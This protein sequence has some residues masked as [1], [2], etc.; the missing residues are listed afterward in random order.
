MVM[1]SP[2]ATTADALS[3]TDAI[4]GLAVYRRLL[5]YARPHWRYLSIAMLAM[6][7]HATTETGFA[8]L[9]G[10]L[11]DG[12]FVNQD[13]TMIRWIPVAVIGI[14][15]VRAVAGFLSDYLMG[16]VAHTVVKSLRRD[17]FAHL[18]RLPV[19]YY[20]NHSSG[21]L[22]SM[23][24]Y[25]T[26]QVAQAT[27]NAVTILV[28]DTLTIIGLLLWMFYLDWRL[29]LGF[30]LIG[31]VITLLV[32]WVT[33]QFR[34]IS[35]RIQHSMGAI[36]QVAEEVL[37][38]QRVVKIFGGEAYEAR[39]FERVNE[40]TRRMN[41]KMSMVK[42]ANMPFLQFVVAIAV[43]AILYLATRPAV[44][45]TLTVGTFMS[46]VAAMLM[47]LDPIRHLTN[48][49][50][51]IQR[52]IAAGESVF[53][54]MATPAEQDTGT[55]PLQRAAGHIEYQDVHLTYDPSKGEVLR[56]IGF[57]VRPGERIALVG[58]S[59]GG[60]SSLV[61]LLPR[62]YEVSEGRILLDGRD[63]RDY[64]LADLRTQI[65]YVG[66]DVTLFNDSIR[67]NIAYGRLE[68]V[69]TA[70]IWEAAEAAHAREFIERLP[71]GLDTLVGDNGVLLSGGQRQR[72]AIA[73]ALLKDAPIL[74]LDEATSSL[75]MEAERHIQDA[76]EKLIANRTTLVIAH[77]LATVEDADRI[78]VLENGQIVEA[79]SHQELLARQGRYAGLY[80]SQFQPLGQPA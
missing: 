20:D 5:A 34:R 70:A 35:R 3:A 49:N 23:L 55:L 60:K 37:E 30:L 79:G 4:G 77:R 73:R 21:Q 11:V 29:T 40:H 19:G 62:F 72:L 74:I 45:D 2:S 8:A 6:M 26:A 17:V 69:G 48:V 25:N 14:F 36:T 1:D 63:V 24:T 59:G 27:S 66:Q 50:A 75:D 47:L 7:V 15:A 51:M 68:A 10:P 12:S 13:P 54:I 18:L 22:L 32:A 80:Q 39:H 64:R 16:Y 61:N 42:A 28:R 46:F 67:N 56:G 31:P 43:A 33:K 71:E 9:V 52:G 58:R 76:I 44:L 65:A 57:A 41:L 53:E 78:L 38:G